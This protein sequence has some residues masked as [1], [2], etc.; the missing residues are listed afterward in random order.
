[1]LIITLPLVIDVD[2]ATLLQ[3]QLANELGL[4]PDATIFEICAAIDE[5]GILTLTLY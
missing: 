3:Q 5:Q 4:D 1:M 2:V